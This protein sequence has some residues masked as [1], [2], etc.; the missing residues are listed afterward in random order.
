MIRLIESNRACRIIVAHESWIRVVSQRYSVPVP[1]IEA[2]LYKEMI[3]IDLVDVLADLTVL[4]GLP[5]KRDSSTGY[6]QIFGRV[7]L[8]AANFAVDRG[9]ATYESLGIPCPHRLNPANREDVRTV[10]KKLYTDTKANI[11]LATIN[12]LVAADEVIGRTDF[13]TFSA[14]ELKRVLSRYNANVRHVTSYGEDAYR[15]Y[16]AFA[17]SW[18]Q[19]HMPARSASA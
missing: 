18:N 1:V 12:L 5:F 11:E 2:I 13:A 17:A 4:A 3:A 10:W 19:G 6:A 16:E 14:D 15:A 8:A 7:G 9:L